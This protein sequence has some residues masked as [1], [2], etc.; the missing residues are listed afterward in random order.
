MGSGEA[1]PVMQVT[2]NF[3]RLLNKSSFFDFDI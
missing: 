2:T 3:L 1:F